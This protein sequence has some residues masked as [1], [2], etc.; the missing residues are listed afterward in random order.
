MTVYDVAVIGAGASGGYAAGL[1]AERGLFVGM[2]EKRRP[3]EIDPCCTGIVGLPYLGLVDAARSVVIGNARSALI[4]SPSGHRMRVEADSPQAWILDRAALEL[5]LLRRA[6]ACGV[7]AHTGC[8]VQKIEKKADVLVLSISEGSG[9]QRFAAH[10]IVVASG[11]NPSITGPLG[12]GS[13]RHHLVGAHALV[14]MD[15]LPETEVYLMQD[16]ERGAFGW[17]VPTADGLARVGVLSAH[18]AVPLLRRLLERADVKRRFR[19]PA[20]EVSRRPVPVSPLP[21]GYGDRVVVVG[22]ALGAVKPTTG[23]GLYFGA[24]S[25]RSA[26]DAMLTAFER[27]DYSARALA[28]HDRTWRREYGD[29]LR[30]GRILRRIYSRLPAAAVDRVVK[31][32]ERTRLAERLVSRPG[33]SFDRHSPDLVRGLVEG[34]GASFLPCAARGRTGHE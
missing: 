23:G 9:E 21:R 20:T 13:T 26:A 4:V 6:V 17:L 33:F 15:G 16:V 32:A 28:V 31:G 7:E 10:S 25:A 8:S 14:D 19:A 2:F 1:L 12:L 29:E 34:L 24:L 5:E 22:D 30:R 27:G 11:V 18:N 3:G